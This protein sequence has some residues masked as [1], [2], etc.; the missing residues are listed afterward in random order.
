MP[1]VTIL[2]T[3]EQK[4]LE[5]THEKVA[6]LNDDENAEYDAVDHGTDIEDDDDSVNGPNADMEAEEGVDDDEDQSEL[7]SSEAF[8][9]AALT[10]AFDIINKRVKEILSEQSKVVETTVTTAVTKPKVTP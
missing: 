2:P 1:Q 10:K 7:E 4:V 3:D 8:R 5:A 9:N 6:E